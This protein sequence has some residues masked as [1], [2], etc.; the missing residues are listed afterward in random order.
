MG[1]S[2]NMKRGRQDR[3]LMVVGICPYL[4]SRLIRQK[5]LTRQPICEIVESALIAF[6][7]KDDGGPVVTPPRQSVDYGSWIEYK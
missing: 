2:W 6:L 7:P 4:R 1:L 5:L 3:T